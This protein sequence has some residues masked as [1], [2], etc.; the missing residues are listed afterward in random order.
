V[1]RRSTILPILPIP[2]TYCA[3]APDGFCQPPLLVNRTDLLD[4]AKHTLRPRSVRL[5]AGFLTCLSRFY[6][7]KR[8]SSLAPCTVFHGAR[9]TCACSHSGQIEERQVCSPR[10][11]EKIQA[12]LCTRCRETPRWSWQTIFATRV[13]VVCRSNKALST[14]VCRGIFHPR[15]LLPRAAGFL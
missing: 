10:I 8:L 5:S 4:F 9:G 3:F 14:P 7:T 2:D 12:D 1:V 6:S 13:D 15:L 11:I